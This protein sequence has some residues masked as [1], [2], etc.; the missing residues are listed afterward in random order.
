MAILKIARMGH[1][2][3]RRNADLVADPASPEI[4]KLVAD[5]LDTL[6][7]IGGAAR[8]MCRC[9]WLSSMFRRRAPLPNDIKMQGWMKMVT[10]CP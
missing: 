2:I 5:M 7:D 1:P 9:A 8:S 3:L 4:A 6:A 10:A